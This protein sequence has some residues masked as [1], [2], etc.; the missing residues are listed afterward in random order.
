MEGTALG[1]S[2][3]LI[4]TKC[5][6]S[7]FETL[8]FTGTGDTF[9]KN[10]NL[11]KGQYLVIIETPD[12][13]FVQISVNEYYIGCSYSND[14]YEVLNHK[15]SKAIVNGYLDISADG[16]WKITIEALSN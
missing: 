5:N 10:V 16:N 11:P 1:H 12:D 14:L 9:I 3:T 15:V 6:Q 4:C 2:D 8:I 7:T 13:V